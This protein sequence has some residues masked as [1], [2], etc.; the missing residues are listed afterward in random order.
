M[1]E[2]KTSIESIIID[3]N[4][5]F[6][7]SS[8]ILLKW[9]VRTREILANIIIPA[10]IFTTMNF[11]KEYIMATIGNSIMF[12]SRDLKELLRY[13]VHGGKIRTVIYDEE[14]EKIYSAGDDRCIK[15]FTVGKGYDRM[16]F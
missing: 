6:S 7:C 15:K 3:N 9:E 13:P 10:S 5:G 1:S 2:H 14:N 16:D 4:I 12:L 11:Y 8:D